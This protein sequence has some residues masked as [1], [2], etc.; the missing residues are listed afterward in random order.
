MFNWIQVYLTKHFKWIFTLLL[1]VIIVSFVFTI[2]NFNPLGGGAGGRS[3]EPYFGYNLA[4]KGEV[5]AINRDAQ[6]SVELNMLYYQFRNESDMKFYSFSRIA[7]LDMADQIGIPD[8]DKVEFQEFVK[9]LA[10]FM[11]FSTREFD[12]VRYNQQM[13]TLEARG[14][15]KDYITKI[16]TQDYK[17][18]K[19]R[20]IISGP[21]HILSFEALQEAISQ[22]TEW[23]IKVANLDYQTFAATVE[24]TQEEIAEYYDNN[25]FIYEEPEKTEAAFLLFDPVNFLNK[26][27]APTEIELLEYFT[28]N[29]ATYQ[30]SVAIPA[31]IE[32]EDGTT[33]AVEAPEVQL[34]DVQSQVV[35][36]LNRIASSKLAQA[37]ADD[38]AYELFNQRIELNSDK[39]AA[40]LSEYSVSLRDLIPF[41]ASKPFAQNQLSNATLSKAVA[42][43]ESRY[44]SDTIQDGNNFVV[45][46]RK[47]VIA[48]RIPAL[49]EVSNRVQANLKEE[50]KREAFIAEGKTLSETISSAVTSG[51]DF[52]TAAINSDLIVKSY[53]NFKSSALP[54]DFNNSY[55]QQ[56]QG[57]KEGAVSG[58]IASANEGSFVYL[59]SK[60]APEYQADNEKATA[61]IDQQAPY[62]SR[63]SLSSIILEMMTNENAVMGDVFQ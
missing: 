24:T 17:I 37:A 46:I 43:N 55:L 38:F 39:F 21:S 7:L 57:M 6:L 50:K 18:E 33:T 40:L 61:V 63:Q 42:L 16:L 27:T 47:A 15:S 52:E 10:G 41:D 30:A 31:P 32:N 60:S 13:T 44:F 48:S 49:A 34:A 4:N 51:E 19:V 53:E 29:K 11:S 36:E 45:L 25:S 8:P 35:A 58:M 12:Q 14:I 1:G 56:A 22:D 54:E 23:S 20:S 5:A 3:E 62:L 2:G 26:T 9:G 28:I 59:I